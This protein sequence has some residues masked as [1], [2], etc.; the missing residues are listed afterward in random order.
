[1]QSQILHIAIRLFLE[2]NL[3][4]VI[5]EFVIVDGVEEEEYEYSH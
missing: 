1:M 3:S 4:E 2:Y 5:Y